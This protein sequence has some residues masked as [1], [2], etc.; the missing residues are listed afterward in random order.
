MFEPI[1]EF[2]EKEEYAS[3]EKSLQEYIKSDDHKTRAYANYLIGYINT[4][5]QNKERSKEKAHRYL[6]YNLNSEYPHRNAYALF[7]RLEEDKNIVE[8]Y[9]N[10]G[11][12]KYP[13]HPQL[14]YELLNHSQDRASV[15]ARILESGSTDI[16]LLSRVVEVLI[17]NQEWDKLSRVIFRI[18][19][20][21]TLDDQQAAYL[22]LLS[23]FSMLFGKQPNY[24]KAIKLFESAEE[25][26]LNNFFG[27]AHYLG[28]IYAHMK[29]NSRDAAIKYFDRLPTNNSIFDLIDGP[30]YFITVNFFNVY[31]DIFASLECEFENDLPR[32]SKARCLYALYLYYPSEM[33]Y[34]SYRYDENHI[35]MIR[36]YFD[37]TDYN[38]HLAVA[39]I[40]MYCHV[41]KYVEANAIFLL[42]AENGD[43]VDHSD[44]YYCDI[45][46][47][48]DAETLQI[49]VNQTVEFVENSDAF[50]YDIFRNNALDSLIVQLQENGLYT[51]I[52]AIA[53]LYSIDKLCT[54]ENAFYIAYAYSEIHSPKGMGLY[55]KILEKEPD[56]SY[57][58][59]NIGVILEQNGNYPEALSFFERAAEISRE[60][61]HINNAQRVKAKIQEKVKQERAKKQK[62][63]RTIAKNV[64]LEYFEQLGYN[65]H[66]LSKFSSVQDPEVRQILLRD[67]QE[68]AVAIA[69]GQTKNATIMT[70]SIIEALLYAKLQE[71]NIVS[72]TIPKGTKSVK[73]PL[74]EM[75]L[76]DLLFVAEQEAL[77]TPNSIRLSHYIRDYRNFIHPAKEI[78]SKDDV[79]QENVLIMWSILK[80]LIYELL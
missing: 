47:N 54:C 10:I 24:L 69:T 78:R 74:K 61:K 75:V 42:T 4:C 17:E 58:M 45:I 76:A 3:A 46:D 28:L 25:R 62:E 8:K 20:N 59:N 27:Y 56:N 72:Y 66:L 77:V 79:S 68:C 21:N 12:E 23:G 29:S 13:N 44:C 57:V 30:W 70:G 15:I 63:Y 60:S 31:Q 18:Q 35:R 33:Y 52:V 51:D 19:S 53:E 6:L 1:I 50:D 65:E 9:L 37:T 48:A 14:L 55:K 41:Q 11:L 64:N 40:H 5:W 34:D 73:K 7:A 26:D 16:T 80:R 2:I 43:D 39:L 36:E 67:M 22:N 49:I 32:L 38:K 71:K